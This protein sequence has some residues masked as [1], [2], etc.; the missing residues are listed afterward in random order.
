MNKLFDI[1]WS[2]F[3]MVCLTVTVLYIAWSFYDNQTKFDKEPQPQFEQ[4]LIEIK[5]VGD[6]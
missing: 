2:S 4:D 5:K 1:I 6:E 3:V